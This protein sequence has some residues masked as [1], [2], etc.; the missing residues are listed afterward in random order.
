MHQ[1]LAP[2]VV[3]RVR[4]R[5]EQLA[6]VPGR[7]GAEFYRRLFL[8]YPEAESLFSTPPG[9]RIHHLESG[10][11]VVLRNLDALDLLRPALEALGAVHAAAG[12]DPALLEA[13]RDLLVA[14]ARHLAGDTWRDIEERDWRDALDALID[15]M[16]G[17]EAYSGRAPGDATGD[18][19]PASLLS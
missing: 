7:L 10:L 12:V 5:F 6:A 11:A 2:D 4:A 17:A 1:T 8:R 9:I 18:G 15:I 19:P 13:S 16:L 3:R 14:S